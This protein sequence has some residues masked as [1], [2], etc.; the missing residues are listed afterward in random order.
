VVI[1]FGG[2]SVMDGAKAIAALI[3]NQQ[4]ILDY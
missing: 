1:G 3:T 2:G 4:P